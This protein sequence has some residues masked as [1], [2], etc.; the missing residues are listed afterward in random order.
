MANAFAADCF[1]NKKIFFSNYILENMTI[2]ET[3]SLIL[4]EIAHIKKG[5]ASKKNLFILFGL[6]LFYSMGYVMDYIEKLGYAIPIAGGILFFVT[7]LL[8]YMFFFLLYVS[9]RYEKQA[10]YFVL[11]EGVDIEI[12]EK[13]LILLTRLND[14]NIDN[15]KSEEIFL[16]HPSTKRR[17]DNLRKI[18]KSKTLNER[19]KMMRKWL[20]FIIGF[21][22]AVISN[23]IRRLSKKG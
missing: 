23:I 8:L 4:H 15:R 13:D 22:I 9:R 2:E 7:L 17:I 3:K 6:I 21:L 14:R 11:Q 10:D 16:T 18:N 5:H 12:Y 1:N 20:P 19:E